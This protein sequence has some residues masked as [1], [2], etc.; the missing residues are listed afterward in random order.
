[1]L[2]VCSGFSVEQL[3]RVYD[4]VSFFFFFNDTATTEIYTLSLHD[5][6]PISSIRVSVSP[7]PGCVIPYPPRIVQWL[8]ALLNPAL[9][10]SRAN[11]TDTTDNMNPYNQGPA[12]QKR[13]LASCINHPK[14]KKA[15]FST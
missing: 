14:M 6:L 1:M 2:I 10:F 8:F 13:G 5:A 12:I 4:E 9:L 7:H 11:E 15:P 3:S